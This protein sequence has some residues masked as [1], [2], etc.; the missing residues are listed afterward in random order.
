MNKKLSSHNEPQC[1][2]EYVDG[3]YYCNDD[4][5]F[6]VDDIEFESDSDELID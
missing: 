1:D 6:L 4:E 2:V 5:C 3:K